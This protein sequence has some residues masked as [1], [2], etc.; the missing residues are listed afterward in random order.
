MSEKFYKEFCDAG[1]KEY[2]QNIRLRVK[3]LKRASEDFTFQKA[4]LKA[5]KEDVL[6]F[7]NCFCWLYEPRPKKIKGKKMPMVIPFITWEH[8]DPVIISAR[9]TLGFDDVGI[10]KSRGEGASWIFIL[11][12]LH[13]WLFQPMSAIGFISRTEMAV[14]NPDD[15]DSLMWKLDWELTKLPPWMAGERDKDYMRNVSR[16]IL[17]N[18]RNGSQ[19]VGYTATGDVTTGG[20]KYW[21]MFDE[22]AK[23]P[24]PADTH[25][26][27]STQHVTESR[28][29]ISTPKGAEGEYYRIMHAPS[30]MVKLVLD[31]KQNETRNKG[32]YKLEHGVPVAAD[33]K[34]NPLAAEYSPPNQE[35]L[36]MFSR[37]RQNGFKLENKLRSPWYDR[38]CD[39][40]GATPQSIA[41]ELDRDYGGSVYRIMGPEFFKKAE[42]TVMPFRYDGGIQYAT[43]KLPMT[44]EEAKG[45]PIKVWCNLDH[46]MRPPIRPYA[47]GVDVSSG[48][49]GSHTSNSVIQVI[50]LISMEQVME[51]A[52]NVVEPS[53]FAE[54]AMSI[55]KWFH[56]AYLAWE[57]NYGGG[58]SKRVKEVGYPNVFMRTVWTKRGRRKTQD[59]GWHTNPSSKE[60]G[61]SDYIRMITQGEVK[62]KSRAMMQESGEYVR[63]NGKIEHLTAF[64]SSNDATKGIAHGD[65]V[66]AF[67]VALQAA[68]DRPV[69]KSMSIDENSLNTGLIPPY[70]MAAR[71]AERQKKTDNDG[72]DDREVG[73]LS[74]NHTAKSL[75]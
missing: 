21:I 53:E 66:M 28:A 75:G 7:F 61:F 72:W 57:I 74:G 69:G 4:L 73:M 48:L 30:N 23:F 58:F 56:D 39:R 10:E 64:K 71:I 55:C 11:L 36:D 70:P 40:P 63:I 2:A 59:I 32:L 29:L 1:G 8:Q 51:Y 33:S 45:G 42:G 14:D 16:H 67:V 9:N 20:R 65:R 54:Q 17:K 13:D 3:Y 24:R 15:P 44:I 47:V 46:N 18:L 60:A 19:V 34:E 12:A 41:Q 37:L 27:A 50:D 62:I 68:I 26:M 43:A 38:Q 22:L 31:W 6:F 25:A 5:C 35:V 49:G 52:T